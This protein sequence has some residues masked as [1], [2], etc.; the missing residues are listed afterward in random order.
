MHQQQIQNRFFFSTGYSDEWPSLLNMVRGYLLCDCLLCM[1][2]KRKRFGWGNFKGHF[3]SFNRECMCWAICHLLC[4]FD[5]SFFS[6]PWKQ[7]DQLILLRQEALESGVPRPIQEVGLENRDHSRRRKQPQ[8]LFLTNPGTMPT[9]ALQRTFLLLLTFFFMTAV[10]KFCIN[11]ADS[12]W[13]NRVKNEISEDKSAAW[14]STLR[15]W[16][17]ASA[18]PSSA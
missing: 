9:T 17:R 15:W 7:V 1:L 3:H 5:G 13:P 4:C 12:S 18:S 2:E 16:F 14:D 8:R 10:Q 6:L 11:F